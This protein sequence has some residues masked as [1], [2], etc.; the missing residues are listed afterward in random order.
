MKKIK[1]LHYVAIMNR[2]GQETFIMN[3]FRDIDKTKVNFDFLCS[4]DG[5]GDYDKEIQELGGKILH[6]NLNRKKGKLKQLDNFFILYKYLKEISAEYE[7]FHI[8]TQ[9]AMDGFI[10]SLAAKLA[11][12]NKVIVHSHSTS[13]LF[14]PKAHK[15]FRPF[16]RVMPIEK[17]ACS[18]IAGQWLFGKKA[19]FTIIKNGVDINKFSYN[20]NVRNAI[21]SNNNWDDKFVIGHTGSFTYP[22]NHEYILK[23]FKEYLK[24]NK[25]AILV[26]T[27]K[28]ELL[29]KIKKLAESMNII[30]NVE[31]LGS[32]S[33]VNDLYQ[34]Y[35]CFLFPSKYEGLPV[36]LVEAQ[37]SGLVCFI[38]NTIT[39]EIDVTDNICRMDI[40]SEPSDW[41]QNINK[42]YISN[43]RKDCSR[44][45]KEKGFD[46]KDTA[47]FLQ[48]FYLS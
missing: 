48:N 42:V 37:C 8:H 6:V 22:K 38:S 20:I 1:V 46:M 26:L 9:H 23:V 19:K 34:G 41:A 3:V 4:N 30:D 21:R 47:I 36:V 13:T 24:L 11:G 25:N 45:I 32:R 10:D 39:K 40:S 28:G 29:P 33:D 14:H 31:F 2:A 5:V 35:D 27:G 15:Y 43:N 7:V 17:F 12:I 16:L 18:E 44:I